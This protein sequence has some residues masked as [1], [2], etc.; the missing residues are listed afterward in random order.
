MTHYL[1]DTAIDLPSTGSEGGPIR[2]SQHLRYASCSRVPMSDRLR[3]TRQTNDRSPSSFVH[4]LDDDSLLIIFSFCRPLISDESKVYHNRHIDEGEWNRER[5]WHRLIQVCRRWRYLILDSA[6]HLQV[7]LVCGRGTPVAD[8]LAHS[9][10]VPLIIDHID[11]EY[12][13][14]TPEDE[15]G[16]VLALQH[17][18][19]VRRVRIRKSNSILQ[20]LVISLEGEFP[21]LEFLS[22]SNR[23]FIR[24]FI[25]LIT[26]LSFPE[27]FRAPHLRQLFLDNFATPIESPILTTMGNLVTLWLSSIPSSGYFHPNVLLQRLSLMPQLETLGIGF[28][29]FNPRRDIEKSLLRTPITTRV[30]LPNLHWLEFDGTIAYLG[31]LLPWLTTPLLERLDTHFFNQMIYSIPHLR[32]LMNTAGNLRLNAAVVNFRQDFTM[33]SVY[34][35]KEAMLATWNMTL[36]GRYLDWQVVSAAQVFHA[37]KTVFSAVEHLY[38]RYNRPNISSEWNRQ[39]DRTHWRKFLGSFGKVKTLRVENELVEQVSC[40]LQSEEV[41][42]PTELFPELQELSYST[43]GASRAFALFIDA[44]QKAGRP[45]TVNL[46]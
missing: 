5:W 24:P 17:R 39:A 20:K 9:P 14:L 44:R 26:N 15:E 16:I 3:K 7:S 27:T 45:L 40:A 11:E 1:S 21:I 33:L 36:G 13:V 2:D 41:D 28:H 6:F 30:T 8:M 10:P 22:I 32:Q 29:S 38:L 35:Y 31:A 12:D 34:P 43:R 4:I 19:R 25:D 42:S 18:D 37:L 23:R 46:I